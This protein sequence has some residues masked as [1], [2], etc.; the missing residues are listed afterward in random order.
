MYKKNMPQNVSDALSIAY[1]RR[2]QPFTTIN[3]SVRS[4]I[5]LRLDILRF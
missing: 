3:A 4:S 2:I 1:L 5:L